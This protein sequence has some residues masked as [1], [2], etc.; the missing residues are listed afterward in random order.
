MWLVEVY[1]PDPE[2]GEWQEVVVAELAE[3]DAVVCACESCVVV[4][5][6]VA[7]VEDRSG[8]AA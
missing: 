4:S 3:A 7:Y 1:C 5:R 6:V 8:R 2:C